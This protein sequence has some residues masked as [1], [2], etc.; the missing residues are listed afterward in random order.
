MA[1]GHQPPETDNHREIERL[2]Q[3]LGNRAD[4]LLVLDDRGKLMN[5]T[6][7]LQALIQ[8]KL[9]ALNHDLN[10][11]SD[12]VSR[13]S[14]AIAPPDP[15]S[16][17]AQFLAA[18]LGNRPIFL[19][20]PHWQYQEWQQVNILLGDR[21][22]SMPGIHIPTGGSSGQIRFAM[23][24]WSTLGAAIAGM[25]AHFFPGNQP[26][27]AICVL[28]L[29]HVSGLMQILRA[30]W[31]GGQVILV[32][33]GIAQ[34]DHLTPLDGSAFFLSLVP[35]QLHQLLQKPPLWP[36]L[37]HCYSIIIG[38]APPWPRLLEAAFTA[39][40]P[41]CLSYGMTETAAL[42]A[43]Q[44]RGDFLRGDRS[45]GRVLPHGQIYVLDGDPETG[46][47]TLAIASTSLTRGYYPY[48]FSEPMFVTDDL[49]YFDLQGQLHLVGRQSRKI[50]SGGEN[51]YPEAIEAALYDT[52]LVQDVYVCGQAHPHWGEQV[53]AYYV[54]VQD[55]GMVTGDLLAQ[56]L[57]QRLAPHNCP[58]EWIPLPK[59]PRNAQGKVLRHQLR[60]NTH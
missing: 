11:E 13:Q 14:L 20:N 17:L 9:A 46:I 41:L 8:E 59:L 23:H 39:H 2:Y 60:N 47:G 18:A 28:P 7:W 54:P 50:I 27:N 6:P 22:P 49:G 4:W 36:W 1:H 44:G 40:F 38:G 57:K 25:Q 19:G 42:I 3:C 30:L 45:C 32:P 21:P 34:L 55:S 35:T 5:Q 26:L 15:I 12:L 56:E 33:G 58:K 48:P 51:I 16:L 52:G 43:C 31:T 37:Q 29:Y 53:T 24:Q 10:P